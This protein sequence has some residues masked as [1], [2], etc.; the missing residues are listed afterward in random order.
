M[1]VFTENPHSIAKKCQKNQARKL[2]EILL[3]RLTLVVGL[4]RYVTKKMS[5]GC[6]ERL[7]DILLV[8]T[9]HLGFWE[10]QSNY[11][12][13]G[14]FAR[15]LHFWE[16]MCRKFSWGLISTRPSKGGYNTRKKLALFLGFY[17]RLSPRIFLL[18]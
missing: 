17:E 3:P 4:L 7:G 10:L 5:C 1:F 9:F 15:F 14:T 11:K 16:V 8:K 18:N 12:L 6:T 13:V 2:F